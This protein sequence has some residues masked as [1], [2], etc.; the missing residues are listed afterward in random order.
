MNLV[1]Q[2]RI[3]APMFIIK[4]LQKSVLS[5]GLGIAVSYFP[6]LSV[7]QSASQVEM[8]ASA[9]PVAVNA[10]QRLQPQWPQPELSPNDPR[11]VDYFVLGNKLPVLLISD[12]NAEK[13]AA[14]LDVNVGSGE[15]PL[16]RAG[17]AQG[18]T[19]RA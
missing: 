8:Q 5:L 6:L 15:D 3:S 4:R 1:S 17:L 18:R 16:E 11:E 2:C 19:P 13:A 9:Q 10:P 14:A 12:P 7:A